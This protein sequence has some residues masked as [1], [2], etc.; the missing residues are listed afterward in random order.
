MEVPQQWS[1]KSTQTQSIV[2]TVY[3]Q[4]RSKCYRKVQF[5]FP[6][7]FQS[8]VESHP[9][10]A[11]SDTHNLKK[12]EPPRCLA[13]RTRDIVK[14]VLEKL[15]LP[16]SVIS[17]SSTTSFESQDTSTDYNMRSVLFTQHSYLTPDYLA[18]YVIMDASV[19]TWMQVLR[20]HD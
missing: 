7:Q 10:P 17:Y 14:F 11:S 8:L 1:R 2:K 4:Q 19:K 18:S 3:L 6:Q 12:A 13:L 20:Q 15:S 5:I 9:V 16:T